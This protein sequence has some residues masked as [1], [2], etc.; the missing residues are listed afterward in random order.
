[1]SE[2]SAY[3]LFQRGMAFLKLKNP[4]QAALIL[5]R[6]RKL[7][8][9]KTSISEALGRAYYNSGDYLRAAA[10]FSFVLERYPT[11]SY[12]HYCLGRCAEKLGDE[13]LSRKH[14]RLATVMGYQE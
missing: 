1:M 14:F 3:D 9:E 4:A 7:E 2:E 13:S 12:A 8:P 11:N 5:S 6:A 10:E